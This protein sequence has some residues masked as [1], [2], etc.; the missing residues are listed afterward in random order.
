MPYDPSPSPR[1]VLTPARAVLL[2]TLT[3]GVL[4]ILDAFVFFGVRNGV[5][6][7]RI[8]HSIAAGLLGREAARGG[9]LATAALGL[10]LHFFIAFVVVAVYV[11]ASRKLPILARQPLLFGALYGLAVY[12]VMNY[13]VLPLSAAGGAAASTPPWPVL[14]NGLLIHMLG[15]G[16]PSALFARAASPHV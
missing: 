11:Y 6:P 3:V 15:V 14:V 10:V 5:S 8:L 4:D 1:K 7:V 12:G 13:V 2:G 9:G 16:I